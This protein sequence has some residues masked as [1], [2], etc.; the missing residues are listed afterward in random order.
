[1]PYS[2]DHYIR[3]LLDRR[4]KWGVLLSLTAIAGLL[5]FLS[6]HP[7]RNCVNFAPLLIGLCGS[8]FVFIVNCYNHQAKAIADGVAKPRE[9]RWH[10]YV[11]DIGIL[12]WLH[13]LVPVFV[14]ALAAA[15]LLYGV[16][17]G[18]ISAVDKT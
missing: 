15:T 18:P 8:F 6:D 5:L 10:E 13:I 11:K 2:D 1:M 14:G 17:P 4:E 3:E 9:T 12:G 7:H 16:L